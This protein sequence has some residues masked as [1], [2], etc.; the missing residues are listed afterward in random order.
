[1]RATAVRFPL[2]TE[3]R[4]QVVELVH[5]VLASWYKHGQV[6][7]G[8]VIAERDMEVVAYVVLPFED[9]LSATFSNAYVRGELAKLAALEG[10]PMIEA[11]GRY[12]DLDEVCACG[13]WE[14]LLL[15]TTYLTREPPVRCGG[16]FRPVPL[17]R[18]PTLR[19]D[20]HLDVLHWQADYKACDT[21][22]MH[23]ATGERF[24]EREL[25]AHDSSLSLRGRRL[26]DELATAVGVPV[27]YYLHKTRGRS[28]ELERARLCPSCG[29]EWALAQRLHIFDFRCEACK[30]LSNVACNVA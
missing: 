30:L 6:L 14:W 11:L 29:G 26:C 20:E 13:R 25:Y 7:D 2:T 21:L 23:T 1:M 3:T 18:I 10:S 15:F 27:Y 22:Q 28:R 9:A 8:W 24:G 12:P 19:D 16:C 5:D 4:Q 17:C